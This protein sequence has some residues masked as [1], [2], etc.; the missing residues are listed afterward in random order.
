MGIGIMRITTSVAIENPPF[1]YQFFVMLMHV[2]GIRLSH[3]RGT[4]LKVSNILSTA[5]QLLTGALEYRSRGRSYYIPHDNPH[6]DPAD[7]SEWLL[8]EYPKIKQ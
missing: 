4:A 7:D 5:G 1:A 2:P 3:A 8:H 6:H